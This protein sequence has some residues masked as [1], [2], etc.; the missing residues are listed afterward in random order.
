MLCFLW[1]GLG[2]SRIRR[3]LLVRLSRHDHSRAYLLEP[4]NNDLLAS[5]QSFRNNYLA[6]K[7]R[8]NFDRPDFRFVILAKNPDLIASLQID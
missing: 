8:P 1:R 6:L 5:L 4:F 3:W 2:R 7:A